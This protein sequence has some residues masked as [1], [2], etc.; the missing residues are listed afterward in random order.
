LLWLEPCLEPALPQ[1]LQPEQVLPE[2]AAWAL[3]PA[4]VVCPVALVLPERRALGEVRPS[5]DGWAA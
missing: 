5:A 1:V 3:P 2:Q 4:L